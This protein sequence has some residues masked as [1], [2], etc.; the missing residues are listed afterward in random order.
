MKG[1]KQRKAFTIVEMVIVIAVIAVLATVMIPTVSGVINKANVS[2]DQQLAASINK[3]LAV[4]EADPNNGTID[5][6]KQLRKAFEAYYDADF[7]DKLAPK[8]GEQGYHYW[9]NA[10][11]KQF[12]FASYDQLVN[13]EARTDLEANRELLPEILLLL[14]GDTML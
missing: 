3:Q 6:E 1:F 7:I 2:A 11:D 9:F 13:G 12:V 14:D 4:W 5:S 10:T 8:S